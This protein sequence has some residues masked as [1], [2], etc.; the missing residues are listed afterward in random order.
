MTILVT[1][2]GLIGTHAA[3]ALLDQGTG[4]VL[5][6][7]DP[8][9]GYI[10]SVVGRDRKIF[11]VERG[12]VRDFPRV[13]DVVLRRGVTRIL[14]TAA[15]TGPL[16]TENPGLAFQVNVAG[17]LNLIEVARMRSLARIVL[18]SSSD[19]Y[20]DGDQPP[21]DGPILEH[22]AGWPSSSFDAAFKAMTEIMALAY[23]RLASVNL[24]VCRPCG[25]YGRGGETAMATTSHAVSEAVRRALDGST[26]DIELAL[27]TVELVYVKDV[28]FALREALFVEKPASRVY[29]VGSGELVSAADVAAA[30]A[31]AV[32]EATVKAE[33]V[34]AGPVRLLDTTAAQRDLA[35][36]PRWPL[37]AGIADLA[38]E[39]RENE[40]SPRPAPK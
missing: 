9:A 25:T 36:A 19:V 3:R 20:G 12:D 4:V 31:T 15:I 16:A 8:S 35:Y 32:P 23:Q 33:A 40:V 24:L 30:I 39:L 11:Y 10:E 6:D 26:S 5:Y 38:S 28:A 37:A 14:H 29:N 13:M 7:P 27:P 21:G 34:P 22:E 2:A 1:G 17:A 18:A